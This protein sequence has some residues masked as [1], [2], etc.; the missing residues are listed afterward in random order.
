MF[1]WIGLISGLM[2]L[3]TILAGMIERRN[4]MTAG[5]A[6]AIARLNQDALDVLKK[7]TKARR[8][9]SIFSD[10]ELRDS[11]DNRKK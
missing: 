4:L 1:S 10:D 2:K 5:E 7:A 11:P 9:V 6:R 3:S 8:A